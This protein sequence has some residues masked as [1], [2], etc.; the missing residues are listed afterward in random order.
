MEAIEKPAFEFSGL[1]AVMPEAAGSSPVDP[2]IHLPVN[3]W[4]C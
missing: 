3:Q 1:M 4:L 2:A